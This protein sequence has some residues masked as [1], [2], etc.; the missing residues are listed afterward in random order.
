MRV[1][2]VLPMLSAGGSEGFGTNLGVYLAELGVEV[3][4]F[5]MA[6]ARRERGQVLLSRLRDAGIEVFG[7]EEHNVRSPANIVHLVHLIRSWRPDVVQANLYGA[8]VL[9][10][11]CKV[12][13][14]NKATNFVHRLA[15]ADL[16]SNKSPSVIR[17]LDRFVFKTIAC[18]VAVADKY[19]DFAQEKSGNKL[20]TIINGGLFP[21][22]VP[23][24]EQKYEA[25]MKLNIP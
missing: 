8:E 4:F 5:L 21:E 18:S 14:T 1:L 25:R 10:A 7:A 19:R 22:S 15:S 20:V 2:Q 3:R 13:S 24:A 12:L 23:S 9:S 11:A 6:G 16:V 17:R